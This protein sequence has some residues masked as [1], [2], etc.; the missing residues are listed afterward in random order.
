MGHCL[1]VSGSAVTI[2][3]IAHITRFT[4]E[5]A[6][7]NY[8]YYRPPGARLIDHLKRVQITQ[9]CSTLISSNQALKWLA[10]ILTKSNYKQKKE[11]NESVIRA[12]LEHI[13][14]LYIHIIIK[15]TR[16]LNSFSDRNIRSFKGYISIR[17]RNRKMEKHNALWFQSKEQQSIIADCWQD[18]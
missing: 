9:W 16:W 3:Y 4:N 17:Y 6:L 11:W 13:Q 1:M 10:S 2:F 8:F 15:V 14:Q 5:E 7:A 18:L 12:G